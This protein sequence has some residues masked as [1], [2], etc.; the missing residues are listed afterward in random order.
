MFDNFS[1]PDDELAIW[2]AL[3]TMTGGGFGPKRMHILL[4]RFNWNAKQLWYANRDELLSQTYMQPE[5]VDKFIGKREEAKPE[6]LIASLKKATVTALHFMHPLYPA[7]L[8]E[9]HDPPLVVFVSGQLK[10]TDFQH[11]IAMVGTRNPTS[12]GQRLAKDTARALG[13]AGAVIASGLAIG[14]DSYSHWGAIEGGGRTIAVVATGTDICYPSSNK[15]LYNA[16]LDGHGVVVSEYMPGTK[17]EKWHFPAR[18]RIV[19]GL[20]RAIVVVEAGETSGALIT[21]RLA[22]EQ[23]RDVF[24]FPGRVDSPMSVGTNALISKQVAHLIRDYKDVMDAL[25][26]VTSQVREVA[27]VVELF[28]REKEIYELLSNEPTHFDVLCE[29]TGVTAGEMSAS[30]TML[31]LAG[32][33]TRHPGDWYSRQDTGSLAY[34]QPSLPQQN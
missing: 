3:H 20:A 31:E 7:R 17:P 1:I 19:S 29:R 4:E 5:Y 33:V 21:A 23:N 10:E 2:L 9:I 15:R 26:W 11:S 34:E 28:G 13:A 14:I 24:A 18:N 16:I 8:R 22:F 27:T 25:E 30:L 12:Y 32:L 6:K